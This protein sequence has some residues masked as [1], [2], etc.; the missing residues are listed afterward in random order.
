VSEAINLVQRD[1]A[2]SVLALD[3]QRRDVPNPLLHDR[4]RRKRDTVQET[5]DNLETLYFANASL[6]T[7]EQALRLHIDTGSSDLWTVGKVDGGQNTK[8]PVTLNYAKGNVN[9]NIYTNEVEFAGF[10]IENQAYINVTGGELPVDD[11]VLGLGPY[12]SSVVHSKMKNGAGDPLLNRI[13]AANKSTP[14]FLSFVL[15]R[16]NDPSE[17]GFQSE[18]TIGEYIEGLENITSS[19]KNP[20]QILP[21]KEQGSQHWSLNVDTIKGPDGEM[22]PYNTTVPKQGTPVAMVDNGFTLPQVPPNVADAIYGRVQGAIWVSDAP[23]GPIWQIPCDQLLNV[24]FYIGGVEIPVHPLD[25]NIG[26]TLP[27]GTSVCYGAFQ[28]SVIDW[29]E[30]S[31]QFDMILGMAFLRNVYTLIDFGDFVDVNKTEKTPPF[32]QMMPLTLPDIAHSDFVTERLQGIDTTSDPKYDLL[33]VN[34]TQ[35]S[36]PR[37]DINTK[38][39]KVTKAKLAVKWVIIIVA[40]LGVLVLLGLVACCFFCLKRRKTGGA[41]GLGLKGKDMGQVYQPI[42][43]YHFAPQSHEGQYGTHGTVDHGNLA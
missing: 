1:T 25:L 26:W 13:F 37:M 38:Q 15:S 18:L 39:S 30:A 28:P 17:F 4:L 33:P 31:Q 9:G 36:P 32:I 5:L 11:G 3:I 10:K 16:E 8:I 7:P 27:N 2:P 29:P 34:Q 20:A 35:R 14:N 23:P 21:F 19:P 43:K 6:G 24:S 22:I 40:I 41:K 42:D 12:S